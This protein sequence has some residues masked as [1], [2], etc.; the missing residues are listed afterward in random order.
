LPTFIC[1]RIKGNLSRKLL[2]AYLLAPYTFH[3]S[4]NSALLINNINKEIDAFCHEVL[5]TLLGIISHLILV[6]LMI[7]LLIKTN[8]IAVLLILVMLLV[9]ILLYRKFQNKL[10][11]WG[12]RAMQAHIDIIRT[13]NH[14]LGGFKETRI[15][16]C[17]S[18]FEEELATYVSKLEQN[19]SSS[20]A[21]SLLPR[22]FIETIMIIFLVGLAIIF[23]IYMANYQD[24]TGVLSIFALASIR[25]IPAISQM[26]NS[27]GAIRTH[28]YLLDKLYSDLKEAEDFS[29]DNSSSKQM[30][31]EGIESGD[32]KSVTDR[33]EFQS[34]INLTGIAYTYPT[35]TK[36]AIQQISFKIKK[37]QSIALIGKSGAGKTS[38]VDVI[39]G[40]LEPQSGE[41][42]VDGQSIYQDLRGWQ[43]LVGYIPQAIFLMDDT[44]ERNIAFGV[45]D[46]LID[47]Q[48]LQKAIADAQ[49]SEFIASLPEGKK[50]S[51]GEQGIRLSGGQRQRIGIA[52]ALYHEREI[53][54]LDEATSALDQET[55]KLV[56]DAIKSLRG[57]KTLII[58]AHRL[59]TVEHCHQIH[60]LEQGQIVK[61]GSYQEVVLNQF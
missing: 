2:R 3:L 51:I 17:E 16:G 21:F 30:A 38:L 55:E 60:L 34:E 27:V 20:Y 36:P 23:L 1:F 22:I 7:V 31:S 49:L 32:C 5:L 58:I 59:T 40:F 39:L 11:E 14:S 43:N 10:R 13:I 19:V 25:L 50:T 61:S 53:L 57:L 47:Q 37:G 56:S 4:R 45:P 29:I 9:P 28:T 18:Y 6:L 48:R 24:L 54:V 35:S 46:P 33:L 44:I 12:E 8:I 41:I 15:I 52:R 26:T 42:T